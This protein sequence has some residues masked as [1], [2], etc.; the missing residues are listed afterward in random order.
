V[1]QVLCRSGFAYRNGIKESHTSL[2]YIEES[3]ENFLVQRGFVLGVL[4]DNYTDYVSDLDVSKISSN[5]MVIEDVLSSEC[6]EARL[7]ILQTTREIYSS[8]NILIAD[9]AAI[10]NWREDFLGQ[11]DESV[12]F[13]WI[14]MSATEWARLKS[15]FAYL[16]EMKEMDE[17]IMSNIKNGVRE[18][19][20]IEMTAVVPVSGLIMA[21]FH[22][23]GCELRTALDIWTN[24]R[25]KSSVRSE[26]AVGGAHSAPSAHNPPVMSLLPDQTLEWTDGDLKSA[27][28]QRSFLQKQ[29]SHFSNSSSVSASESRPPPSDLMVFES[30]KA[31]KISQC[32]DRIGN[33]SRSSHDQS[34]STNWVKV[35]QESDSDQSKGDRSETLDLESVYRDEPLRYCFLE[36]LSEKFMSS[37][38]EMWVDIL[39]FEDSKTPE[40]L[41][42]YFEAIFEKYLS[43]NAPQ[44][45]T[46]SSRL[47]KQLQ[48]VFLSK[49]SPPLNVFKRVKEELWVILQLTC[50]PMFASSREYHYFLE[51]RKNPIQRKI[52]D[53]TIK[54]EPNPFELIE[55]DKKNDDVC[56][57]SIPVFIDPTT[58]ASPSRSH[59]PHEKMA[60]RSQTVSE[61]NTQA[62]LSKSDHHT[63]ATNLPTLLDVKD[64]EIGSER[65]NVRLRVGG[66]KENPTIPR[67]V[68]NFTAFQIPQIRR[69]NEKMPANFSPHVQSL[70]NDPALPQRDAAPPPSSHPIFPSNHPTISLQSSSS[71]TFT[72]E[73]A[74]SHSQHSLSEWIENE[75]RVSGSLP[76][77]QMSDSY[78][79]LPHSSTPPVTRRK[80]SAQLLE[81]DLPNLS[82]EEVNRYVPTPPLSPPD[83]DTFSNNFSFHSSNCVNMSP[84]IYRQKKI[85]VPTGYSGDFSASSALLCSM[86]MFPLLQR[87]AFPSLVSLSLTS[88]TTHQC[89]KGEDGMGERSQSDSN[90]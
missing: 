32:D 65:P 79:P 7:F 34:V 54:K 44:P 13:W 19:R 63:I 82:V 50:I 77:S 62:A 59:L 24:A 69:N 1:A 46:I 47:F 71:S 48:S 56:I 15:D 64:S 52:E 70:A 16:L 55:P 41:S 40:E 9:Y 86:Q 2:R 37:R 73:L 11:S 39:H 72:K 57:T 21:R 90:I 83:Y 36:Y 78:F 29:R 42:C 49:S 68:R 5:L 31:S 8:L 17:E 43:P 87:F 61:P 53:I 51:N 3:S 58:T 74:R 80:F 4:P 35:E 84:N 12:S 22:I 14:D 33:I 20:K 38:F 85:I 67:K 18:E 28:K 89:G 10:V 75:K 45:V 23:I 66:R 81:N 27:E 76:A 60:S 26:L 30:A 6:D 88:R 25:K